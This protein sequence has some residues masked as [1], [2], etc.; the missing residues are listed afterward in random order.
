M[1]SNRSSF[2]RN[3]AVRLGLGAGVAAV[4]LLGVTTSTA[5]AASQWEVVVN[6]SQVP[7]GTGSVKLAFP[8]K[9]GSVCVAMPSTGN[10]VHFSPATFTNGG[11]DF[12]I[13]AFGDTQC[14]GAATGSLLQYEFNSGQDVQNT[15]LNCTEVAVYPNG[16]GGYDWLNCK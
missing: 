14:Q 16:N 9:G 7:S 5:S 15:G 11:Q 10:I 3:R 12:T 4:T 6:K 1:F 2:L 13:Q 8:P